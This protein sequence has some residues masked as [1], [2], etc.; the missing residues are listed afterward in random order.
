M[1]L[2]E[3]IPSRVDICEALGA[4]KTRE[5][6][7]S[8][9][10]VAYR[11][12]R[13]ANLVNLQALVNVML[14]TVVSHMLLNKRYMGVSEGD[15][16]VDHPK[17]NISGTRTI[18]E[19]EFLLGCFNIG[20]FIPALAWL[21]RQGYAWRL[22]K[23]HKRMDE[24]V[25]KILADHRTK[26][27]LGLVPECDQ[28]LVDVLFNQL[29]GSDSS[30]YQFSKANVKAVIL[31]RISCHCSFFLLSPMFR[32]NIQLLNSDVVVFRSWSTLHDFF[33]VCG[34]TIWYVFM[35]FNFYRSKS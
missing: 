32:L 20:D 22:K 27:E 7:R 5:K 33:E 29:E 16:T 30:V 18:E 10:H 19:I 2:E 34:W 17:L 28:D 1:L 14:S 4:K 25:N 24:F 13:R 31:A 3:C 26:R 11:F 8:G 6:W 21:E 23:L 12:L 35:Y 9:V 15:N